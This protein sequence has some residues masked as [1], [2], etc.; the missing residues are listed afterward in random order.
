[1]GQEWAGPCPP[2]FQVA[3]TASTSTLDSWSGVV[4]TNEVPTRLDLRQLGNPDSRKGDSHVL[5]RSVPVYE[6]P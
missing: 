4:A 1:M 6:D 2:A 5:V 3:L